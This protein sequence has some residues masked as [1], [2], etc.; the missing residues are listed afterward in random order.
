MASIVDEIYFRE[1]TVDLDFVGINQAH[2]ADLS[3]YRERGESEAGFLARARMEAAAAGYRIMAV[4][5]DL[6]V[7][8]VLPVSNVTTLNGRR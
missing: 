6:P 5:G 7:T 1:G 4:G 2:A 3:W 8:N